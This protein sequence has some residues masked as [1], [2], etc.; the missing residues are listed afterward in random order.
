MLSNKYKKK[1]EHELN[2]NS[3]AFVINI[4]GDNI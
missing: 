3:S 1:I 2:N 4:V